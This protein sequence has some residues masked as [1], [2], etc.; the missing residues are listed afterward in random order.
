[1]L[2]G[3]LIM[4]L[5]YANRN[6]Y[7]MV[8]VMFSILIL[9]KHLFIPLTPLFA[10]YLLTNYYHMYRHNIKVLLMKVLS[11]VIIAI[12]ALLLAFLPFALQQPSAFNQ[13]EQIFKRLFPWDRGLLHAYWAPN[14]WAIYCAIDLCL[15][16]L[17]GSSSNHYPQHHSSTSGLVGN[18]DYRVLPV[19][20]KFAVLVLLISLLILPLISITKKF[21]SNSLIKSVIYS[22]FTMFMFGYH[23]H[24]KVY[25]IFIIFINS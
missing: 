4:T 6:N 8:T 9:T 16:K 22:T 15:S 23:V 21:D 11:L 3:L 5:D 7:V 24:E 2:I 12:L 20:P 13:L 17:F 18:F 10:I 1:M 14:I 19:V 25:C